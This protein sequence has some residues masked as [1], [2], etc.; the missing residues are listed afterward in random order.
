MFKFTNS[1]LKI[2][3]EEIIKDYY[4]EIFVFLNSEKKAWKTIFPEEKNIF[5]ALELTNFSEIKVVIL[6]QD[7][8]HQ[9]WQAHWLSFSVQDWVKVPPSLRN[10]YKEVKSSTWKEVKDPANWNLENW[11]KQWVLLL[12]T[13]LTVEK[14]KPASHS[15]I[16]WQQFTD[17][18]IEKISQ[19]KENVVFLLWGWFAKS[20]AKLIDWSK[21]LI[22]ETSHPSPLWS[23]RGFLWS[24]C[25]QETNNY[26]VSK[27]LEKINW[28]K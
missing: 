28:S 13:V 25:F 5:R 14:S 8:Y 7:P 6:G 4:K 9:E 23:Y 18:I 17:T 20:K 22:L 11:A 19:E 12:N 27:W 10:I 21:H 26:L 1:W 16:W 2:L 24:N 3:S 15:K